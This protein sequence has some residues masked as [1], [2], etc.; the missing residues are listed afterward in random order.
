MD[1]IKENME[2]GLA[3]DKEK[4]KFLSYK[5]SVKSKVI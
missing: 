2:N 3:S 4:L 5:G 1:K